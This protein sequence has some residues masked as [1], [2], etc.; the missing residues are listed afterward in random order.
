M[1]VK[2]QTM[3][4]TP[5]P[6]L[7]TFAR[8][9][10]AAIGLSS[11]QELVRAGDVP[12]TRP[13]ECLVA[14]DGIGQSPAFATLPDGGLLLYSSGSFRTSA[15]GG[16]TWSEPWAPRHAGSNERA[17][18]RNGGLVVFKDSSLGYVGRVIP[19][20]WRQA[21]DDADRKRDDAKA[22]KVVKADAAVEAISAMAHVALWRSRD[23]GRTWSGPVRITPHQDKG[24]GCL[25]N[26]L[27][28]SGSGRLLIP[29]YTVHL[30]GP[31]HVYF[32]DDEGVTWKQSQTIRNWI[33]DAGRKLEVE[34]TEP[35]I[36]E[37]R[38]GTILMLARTRTGRLFQ[39]WSYDN[40]ETWTE[41]RASLLA[42]VNS[43]AALARLPGTNDV[44]VAWNQGS[45]EEA[46][47]GHYRSRL[48]TAISRDEGRTW[49]HHQNI[50]S[51]LGQTY[52]APEPINP[53][54][55]VNKLNPR[56]DPLPGYPKPPPAPKKAQQGRLYGSFTYPGIAFVRDRFLIGHADLHWN[57]QGKV[58]SLG[59]LRVM[60]VSWLYGGAESPAKAD[61]PRAKVRLG[62]LFL[63]SAERLSVQNREVGPQVQPLRLP[64]GP[65]LL[66]DDHV[67][68]STEGVTRTLHQPEKRPDPV[69]GPQGW[70][71]KVRHFEAT[72]DEQRRKFR[73][74]YY[75][76][77]STRVPEK[78]DP[79]T[80]FYAYAESDD[81]IDWRQPELGL[82]EVNGSRKNN[83]VAARADAMMFVDHGPDWL[84]PELRYLLM[85]TGPN[86]TQ[87]PYNPK[88][89]ARYARYSADGLWFSE[90][91]DLRNNPV[92][93][94]TTGRVGGG[95]H[96]Y[97]DSLRRRYVMLCSFEAEASEGY[98]GKPPDKH[99]GRRRLLG[100]ATSRDLIHWT[101]F[102]LVLASDPEAPGLEQMG[103]MSVIIR[104][105]LYIGMVM[106]SN[107]DEPL[108]P[109]VPSGI[110]KFTGKPVSIV[111]TKL[112]TSRDGD[113]WTPY[114]GIFL[115]RGAPG[116][117]DHGRAGV[118]SVVT[119]GDKE[120]LYYNGFDEGYRVGKN[121]IGLATM[122]KDG[123]VSLDAGPQG[124]VVRTRLFVVD[125]DSLTVNAKVDGE[126]KVRV[127]D[128]SGLPIGGFFWQQ[129]EPIKG[130]SVAHAVRWRRNLG[131]LK[132]RAVRLEFSLGSAQFYGF[133]LGQADLSGRTNRSSGR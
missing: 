109:E 95:I 51:S 87:A 6:G 20:E 83:A 130:D 82:V 84:M 13:E 33:E 110:N 70:Y 97:W 129:C 90:V 80:G 16:L 94:D 118:G 5:S 73:M 98:H 108:N 42:S 35:S 57:E 44:V 124:G 122:R 121:A 89:K 52:V 28:R 62:E 24:Q 32:S 117:W 11:V 76:D 132:G 31:I 19:A 99:E 102:R 119:F 36:V 49:L 96:G 111:R 133:E 113:N 71:R 47:K 75:A 54:W 64:S 27:I 72:Y 69:L 25:H 21:K 120:Y 123:F 58:Q 4:M 50:E 22:G 85:S 67:V 40:G 41:G 74:W 60:P 2:I 46:Q 38:P 59:R 56:G 23:G 68:E 10:A 43:P 30:E 12:M 86:V 17:P 104:G 14:H 1:R 53:G 18:L 3:T 34:G 39:A 45:I 125:G 55:I 65:Q 61:D 116:A 100:Q 112:Y 29:V 26:A 126:I 107:E 91:S 8:F 63:D 77:I 15:D 101:P 92:H 7:R 9:L 93:V 131:E 115:D 114:P 79:E 66:L 128:P 81:G 78:V 88:R 106:V 127:L 103:S 37:V 105:G 48:S